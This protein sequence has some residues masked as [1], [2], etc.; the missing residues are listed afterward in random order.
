MLRKSERNKFRFEH[1]KFDPIENIQIQDI[2]LVSGLWTLNGPQS[3]GPQY[4][5]LDNGPF[6]N[7]PHNLWTGLF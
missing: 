5:L 6:D 2:I 4:Y 3:S 1:P 7:G